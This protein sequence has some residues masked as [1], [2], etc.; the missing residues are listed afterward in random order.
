M[1]DLDIHQINK[2]FL[3]LFIYLTNFWP[4]NLNLCNLFFL[5]KIRKLRM[6]FLKE[7]YEET[8][9]IRKEKFTFVIR[10][11]RDPLSWISLFELQFFI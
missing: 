9:G 11:I 6:N 2:R 4:F 7:Y 5:S 10:I 8:N 1:S 3:Y